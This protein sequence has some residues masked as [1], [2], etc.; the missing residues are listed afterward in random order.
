M[1]NQEKIEYL[2]QYKYLNQHIEALLE[3]KERWK[4][5]AEK[6][7]STITGMPH[8]S[9][10]ENPR[11]LAICRM[12]DCENVAT[13]MIDDFVDLGNNIKEAIENVDDIVLRL[14]L[15]HRYIE[16]KKFEEIAYSMNISWRHIHRLHRKALDK[17]EV[18]C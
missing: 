3:E 13:G 18:N 10:G 9:D 2:K 6:V 11:E 8:G 1:T 15:I 7:T 5:K 16:G 12:I 17:I 14:V 4:S